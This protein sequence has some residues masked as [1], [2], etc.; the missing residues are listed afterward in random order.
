MKP[1]PSRGSADTDDGT[2]DPP[3]RETPEAEDHPCPGLG[4]TRP[5]SKPQTQ[6]PSAPRPPSSSASHPGSKSCAFHL[7]SGSMAHRPLLGPPYPVPGPLIRL[8]GKIVNASGHA[9]SATFSITRQLAKKLSPA[10]PRGACSISRR[11]VSFSPPA[12][13]IPQ[14]LFHPGMLV[15]SCR[16]HSNSA[17]HPVICGLDGNSDNQSHLITGTHGVVCPGSP[18][19]SHHT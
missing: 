12:S 17:C 10:F 5:F 13:R 7:D 4:L 11:I 2:D 16:T 3:P 14:G 1:L 9:L 18:P 6:S 19:W 8:A 15:A